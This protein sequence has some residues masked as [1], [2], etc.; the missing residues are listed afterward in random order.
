MDH[1]REGNVHVTQ[2]KLSVLPRLHVVSMWTYVYVIVYLYGEV[3]LHVV[4][5][6]SV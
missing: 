5:A 4:V 3:W 1:E 2:E 6:S